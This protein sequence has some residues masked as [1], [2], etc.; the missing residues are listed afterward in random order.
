MTRFGYT[1]EPVPPRPVRWCPCCGAE[2][3]D[4][5]QTLCPGCRKEI[6]ERE[7]LTPRQMQAWKRTVIE[8]DVTAPMLRGLRSFL[9]R[10]GYQYTV[11]ED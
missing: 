7:P 10:M 4:D 9:D 6:E 5:M 8:L 11:R 2:I 1:T 3:Y